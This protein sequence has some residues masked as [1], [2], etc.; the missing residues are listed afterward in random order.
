MDEGGFVIDYLT[1]AGTALAETDARV[2]RI[3]AVLT[4]TPEIAAFSRRTGAELGLFATEHEQG[5][6]PRAAEAA[7]PAHALGRRD[8]RRRCAT[9][10][11]RRRPALEIEF[12][13][14][15]QDMLGDLEG[16]PTP[17]EVKIFGDDP[18][19]LGDLA[20]TVEPILSAVP[21]VVDV[22]GPEAGNPE[23]DVADRSDG[24]R[25]RRADAE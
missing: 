18:A 20:E 4:K 13:Q 17:I 25:A 10:C 14:L 6:H 15:L 24:E 22:V 19:T 9:S 23:V 7:R 21:G 12:V 5:R 1:P 2:R 3:E 8:H 16:A 11:T